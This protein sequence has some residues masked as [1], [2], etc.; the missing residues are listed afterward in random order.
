MFKQRVL[1]VVGAGA[2]AEYGFPTGGRLA[3]IIGSRMDVRYDEWGQTQISGDKEIFAQIYQ[4]YRS[5]SI[6]LEGHQRACLQI[7]DGILF[8]HS[9]D[10][11]LDVH[12]SDK[13]INRMGKMAIVKS[14]LE[15]ERSSSLYIKQEHSSRIDLAT[16]ED[17]W[18]TKFIRMA[19]RGV[20]TPSD[21]F[22]Q[23]ALIVFNY[24]RCIEHFLLSALQNLYKL[25]EEEACSILANLPIIHPYG[26]IG[27]L[28]TSMAP[29]GLRFGGPSGR[30]VASYYRLSDG[31][32][33]YTEQI[34]DTD[35]LNSIRHQLDIAD[36]LVFL[37]FGYHEQNIRILAH[38]GK[39]GRKPIYGTALG[40]SHADVSVLQNDLPKILFDPKSPG[41]GLVAL[42]NTLSSAA[43]FDTFARSL[44]A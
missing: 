4:R 32:S 37:G 29:T 26:V 12:A 18:L 38:K 42:D 3:Q 11:F 44:P 28:Q 43:L 1:F 25:S 5:D 24:D 7:R 6:E 10:D 15:A 20:S 41:T 22:K 23:V 17:T 21:I 31:T 36:K 34:S 33:T 13:R 8:T 2:S 19:A 14:I 30:M 40:I 39:V 16:I 9:I 27:E 35:M